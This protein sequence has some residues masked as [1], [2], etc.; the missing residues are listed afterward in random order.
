MSGYSSVASFDAEYTDAPASLTITQCTG[1]DVS[2]I[3]SDTNISDSLDAVPFPIAIMS[4][5][6]FSINFSNSFLAPSTSFCGSVGYTVVQ[7][8]TFPVSSITAIL[9]PVLYAGSNPI[10]VFPFIGAPSNSCF[11]FCPNTF[12]AFSSAF[13]VRSERISLSIDGSISLS[14]LSCIVSFSICVNCVS[15]FIVSL[16]I[17]AKILSFGFSIVT[18]R[19]SSFSPLFIASIL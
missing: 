10:T 3:M 7:S 11:E 5:L 4:I 14:K 18:F 9:H 13:S 16:S 6:S 12:I 19:Q 17:Y 15:P 2:F 8:S 1:L